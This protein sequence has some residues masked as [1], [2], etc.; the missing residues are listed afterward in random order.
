[1]I[2]NAARGAPVMLRFDTASGA[3]MVRAIDVR[4]RL[5]ASRWLA[6]SVIV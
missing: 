2:T 6:R 3:M 1:L 5:N 4:Q